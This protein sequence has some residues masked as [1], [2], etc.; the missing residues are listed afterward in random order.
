MSDI[1]KK[2][3]EQAKG[4]IELGNAKEQLGGHG[5]MR[6][7][8]EVGKYYYGFEELNAYFDSISDEEKPKVHNKLKKLKIY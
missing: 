7:I 8:D 4:L 3:K 5:M 2:L 1:V 6:V